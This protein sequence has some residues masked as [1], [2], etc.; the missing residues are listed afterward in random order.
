MEKRYP[1]YQRKTERICGAGFPE[2]LTEGAYAQSM[3]RLAGHA[4]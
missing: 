4:A 1:M 3:K 2:P